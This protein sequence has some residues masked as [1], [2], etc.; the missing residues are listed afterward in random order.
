MSGE[1]PAGINCTPTDPSLEFDVFEAVRLRL[2][3]ALV[4]RGYELVEAERIALY[5]IEV[6]RPVTHFLKVMAGAVPPEDEEIM[7]A[8][9][10][11]IDETPALEKAQRLLLKIEQDET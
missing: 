6:S 2:A 3:D 10:K 11:V 4:R 9:G 5:L 7:S 1:P 8:L